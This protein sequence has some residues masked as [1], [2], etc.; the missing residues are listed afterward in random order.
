MT[1]NPTQAACAYTLCDRPIKARRLCNGHLKQ[2]ERGIPLR[3]LRPPRPA[4][5]TDYDYIATELA[6]ILPY[7]TATNAARRLGY[8]SL[9]ALIR[10]LRKTGH[11]TIALELERRAE[12]IE[13]KRSAA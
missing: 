6:W 11:T 12:G 4:T 3:P 7:D 2:L 10:R 1:G 8:T 5:P 9:N 13:Q